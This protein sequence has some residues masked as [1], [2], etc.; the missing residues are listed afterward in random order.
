MGHGKVI[1]YQGVQGT[2]PGQSLFELNPE[3]WEEYR[4]ARMKAQRQG[5]MR[6]VHGQGDNN[7]IYQVLTVCQVLCKLFEANYFIRL[8]KLRHREVE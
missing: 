1:S 5:N 4:C 8:R 7:G 3:E 6:D 2:L